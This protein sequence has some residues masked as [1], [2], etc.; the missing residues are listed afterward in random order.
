MELTTQRGFDTFFIPIWDMVNHNNGRVNTEHNSFDSEEGAKVWASKNIMAG[1]EFFI[2]YNVLAARSGTENKWGTPELLRD[3]G[4]VEPYPQRWTFRK[5]DIWFEIHEKDGE[6][7]AYFD[8][9]KPDE[10]SVKY[11]EEMLEQ[12]EDLT[13]HVLKK[14]DQVPEHEWNMI[15]LFHQACVTAF[16]TALEAIEGDFPELSTL[17][18]A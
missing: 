14:K 2:S 1:E 12:L 11:L 9:W 6:L 17:H 7:E 4:F 3:F 18:F 15:W 5:P 10:E 13:A 16:S 8:K